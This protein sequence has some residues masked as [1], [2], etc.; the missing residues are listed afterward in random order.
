MPL[1]EDLP[2]VEGRCSTGHCAVLVTNLFQYFLCRQA[3]KF[4]NNQKALAN[5]VE[6]RVLDLHKAVCVT[7]VPSFRVDSAN[8]VNQLLQQSS[9]T[10]VCQRQKAFLEVAGSPDG[11]WKQGRLSKGTGMSLIVMLGCYVASFIKT[12]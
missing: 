10:T 2:L 9:K 8:Q 11:V 12:L 7:P 5:D 4:P 1:V 6:S 3:N